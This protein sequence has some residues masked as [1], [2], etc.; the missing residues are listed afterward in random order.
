MMQKRSLP[1]L[2]VLV[3]FAPFLSGA[4]LVFDSITEGKQVR[5]FPIKYQD[6][7]H[8]ADVLTAL[9]GSSSRL[10]SIWD[11]HANT[12]ILKA[13]K[14]Q[15]E[16]VE[17]FLSAYDVKLSADRNSSLT[18]TIQSRKKMSAEN[19]KTSIPKYLIEQ[20][21]FFEISPFGDAKEPKLLVVGT[22]R[23]IQQV[24]KILSKIE[25]GL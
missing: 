24:V 25:D 23:S 5:E 11:N 7:F 10:L 17:R 16:F 20:L 21:E 13:S 15:H 9:H 3:I 6:A 14:E 22:K 1:I 19:L 12:V 8:I 4:D 2:F 18:V